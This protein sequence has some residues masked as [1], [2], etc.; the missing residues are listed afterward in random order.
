MDERIYTVREVAQK[1]GFTEK[2]I[3]N[4]IKKKK[5]KALK[6]GK[7]YRIPQKELRKLLRGE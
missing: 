3:Y 6:I 7:Q 1:L 5:I 4:Y 2:T